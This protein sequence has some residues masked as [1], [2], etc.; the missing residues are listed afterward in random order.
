MPGVSGVSPVVFD[1]ENAVLIGPVNQQR[2]NLAAIDP[3]SFTTVAPLPDQVFVDATAADT[4][5][6]LGADPRG[7]LVDAETADDLS[8]DVGDPVD[9]VLA[10]GTK[11]ETQE[12]F[13]VVGLFERFPGIPSGANLVV[14]LDR[15]RE[16]TGI[17]AVDVFLADVD[18]RSHAGLVVA[19]ASLRS[20]PGARDPLHI[21]TTETALD[22]DQSSLTA[23]NVNGLVR[24]NTFYALL[25]ERHRH[26][27]LRVRVD[28]PAPRGVRRPSGAGLRVE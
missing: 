1:L 6:M 8:V 18:D 11:R 24:L 28:A 5:A 12:R 15:Y 17:D 4:L 3:T 16:A 21:E 14:D 27:D 9:I 26:R 7:V 13:R 22:D 23:V 25:D 19:V 2:K 10:L 20:G